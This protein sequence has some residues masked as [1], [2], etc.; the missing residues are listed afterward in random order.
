M[1]VYNRS[2]NRKGG[3]NN[4]TMVKL[5]Y[6]ETR[7]PLYKEHF[8]MSQ[9]GNGHVLL[10]WPTVSH[11]IYRFH[12]TMQPPSLIRNVTNKNTSSMT[13]VVIIIYN[14]TT[15][16]LLACASNQWCYTTEV[17]K[18]YKTTHIHYRYEHTD[19]ITAKS[20]WDH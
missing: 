9:D 16:I 10:A 20:V 12:C 6:P 19:A 14:K 2:I 15:R 5:V 11:T 18:N 1:S 3:L 13:Q 7:P 17:F 4:D 8:D